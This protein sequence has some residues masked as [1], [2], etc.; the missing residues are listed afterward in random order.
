MKKFLL[1]LPLLSL[2]LFIAGCTWT[3]QEDIAKINMLTWE[4]YK[5]NSMVNSLSQ[6]NKFLLDEIESLTVA[7]TKV[8]ESEEIVI[9]TGMIQVDSGDIILSWEVIVGYSADTYNILLKQ[10][11]VLERQNTILKQRAKKLKNK[12]ETENQGQDKE[13]NN[14]ITGAV[15][16]TIWYIKSITKD[17]NGKYRMGIDYIQWLSQEECKKAWRREYDA[18]VP[19]CIINDNPIIMTLEIDE[20]VKIKMQTYCD[21][22]TCR[23]Q[24]ILFTEFLSIFDSSTDRK[25]KRDHLTDV[26]YT[27][28][29][30]NDVV[31]EITE[32][33][34]P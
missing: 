8:V 32:Q 31:V 33:Y 10:K 13:K 30:E 34:I 17:S 22:W 24:E 2:V 9:S 26:P 6:E 7:Q 3:S 5:L 25:T 11:L 4:I 14:I 23:N 16:D 28:V 29:L 18:A 20:M 19:F 27:I 15:S 21:E 1:M 12:E